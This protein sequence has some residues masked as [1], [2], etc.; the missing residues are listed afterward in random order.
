MK[1]ERDARKNERGKEERDA[2]GGKKE[3]RG[4]RVNKAASKGELN[5]K[6]KE[7]PLAPSST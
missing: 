4:D 1:F 7:T 5:A 2:R 6:R 3:A